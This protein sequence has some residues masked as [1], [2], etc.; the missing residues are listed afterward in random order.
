MVADGLVDVAVGDVAVVDV[1]VV[2][3]AVVDLAVVDPEEGYAV[4]PDPHAWL[5]A[6][7]LMHA[8]A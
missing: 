2:D 7:A 5:R 8:C 6:R 4:P 3:L 1:A